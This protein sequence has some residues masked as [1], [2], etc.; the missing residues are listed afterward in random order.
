MTKVLITYEVDDVRQWLASP[1]RTAAFESAG[2]T[3]K[4]FVDPGTDGR[5][6]L[7]VEEKP[8]TRLI[9]PYV[10]PTSGLARLQQ[11]ISSPEALD[12]MRRDG[13]RKATMSTYVES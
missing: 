10:A 7:L 2:F 12:R 3:V 13:V 9:A 6:A 11:M 8:R 1:T 5:A 4:T